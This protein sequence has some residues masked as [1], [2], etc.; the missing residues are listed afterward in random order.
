M[1]KVA[2]RPQNLKRRPSPGQVAPV[3]P[4]QFFSKDYLEQCRA[5]SPEQIVRF[6]EDFR[7]LHAPKAVPAKSKLISLKV[8]EPLLES[9]RTKARLN[10]TPYQT[11]IKRLMHD[12]LEL[13]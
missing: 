1:K 12:W 10:G 11:Q 9:F 5:M 7:L 4:V 8:P 13:P 3:R 6:L 2:G